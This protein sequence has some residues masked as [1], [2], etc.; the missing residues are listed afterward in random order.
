MYESLARLNGNF[1]RQR[2]RKHSN[3][4]SGFQAKSAASVKMNI[5]LVS[6]SPCLLDDF[7]IYFVVDTKVSLVL[8]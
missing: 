1:Y 2:V 5:F 3:S 6:V 7:K 4:S 8:C